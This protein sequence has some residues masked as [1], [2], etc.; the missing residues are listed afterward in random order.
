[1]HEHYRDSKLKELRDQLVRFAPKAQKVEQA[2]RAEQ[3][4]GELEP[5]RSYAYDYLCYR[6]TNYR[7]QEASRHT[8]AAKDLAVDLRQLVEDL[9]ESAAVSVEEVDEPV[10]SVDDLSRMFKV[11]T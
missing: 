11:S 5:D 6:I 2:A 8:I 7:P 3:L 1:M 4:I 9:S 10:H